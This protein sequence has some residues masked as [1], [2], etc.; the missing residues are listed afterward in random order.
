MSVDDIHGLFTAGLK[1]LYDAEHRLADAL[2]EMEAQVEDEELA[3]AFAEHESE[4]QTHIDRLEDVFESIDA[5]PE[6]ET[7]EATKGHVEEHEEFVEEHDPSK[8]A[9]ERYN[10]TA[11]Q[12]TEVYEII[13]YEN[14]IQLAEHGGHDEAVD[15]LQ[16]NLEDEENALDKLQTAASDFDY[17]SLNH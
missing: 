17:D 12:K 13:T 10:I 6:R 2:S 1:D 7:C 9:L 3:S 11:A 8:K 16:Q 4:T 15:L 5:D 14:L